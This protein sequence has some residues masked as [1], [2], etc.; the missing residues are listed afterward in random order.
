MYQTEIEMKGWVNEG[1][2]EIIRLTLCFVCMLLKMPPTNRT[3]FNKINNTFHDEIL[4]F[5]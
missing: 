1:G 3:I 4:I 2:N 5:I